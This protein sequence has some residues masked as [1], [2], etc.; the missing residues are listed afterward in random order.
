MTTQHVHVNRTPR[1]DSLLW[2]ERLD[3]AWLGD[4]R[5]A[6]TVGV[7]PMGFEHEQRDCHLRSCWDHCP[8]GAARLLDHDPKRSPLFA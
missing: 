8:V 1:P 4:Q 6:E 2:W 3:A 7:C 5:T